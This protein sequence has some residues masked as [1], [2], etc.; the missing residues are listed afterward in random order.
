MEWI[1]K[2]QGFGL[3]RKQFGCCEKVDE[4]VVW[5]EDRWERQLWR[6]GGL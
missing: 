4:G 3:G 1:C 5:V 2:W 6:F